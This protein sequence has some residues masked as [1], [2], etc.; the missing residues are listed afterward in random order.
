MNLAV[1]SR[2]RVQAAGLGQENALVS[3]SVNCLASMNE[4]GANGPLTGIAL[5]CGEREPAAFGGV[6]GMLV[7]VFLPQPPPA[8]FVMSV[9]LYQQGAK[10]YGPPVLCTGADGC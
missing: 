4:I 9:T 8:D 7:S 2:R 3:K 10:S 1:L 6:P 5:L